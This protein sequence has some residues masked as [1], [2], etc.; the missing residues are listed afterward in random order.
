MH[1][2]FFNDSS[3]DGHSGCSHGLAI[4][5]SAAV[6]LGV[7]IFLSDIDSASFRYI[8]R[9]G[10]AGPLGRANFNI[11]RDLHALFRSGRT[12]LHNQQCEAFPFLHF[13]ANTC[14][15]LYLLYL[16]RTVQSKAF[17]N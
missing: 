9:H 16:Q 8:L 5:N 14:Y 1:L 12:N 7:Q 11:L 6:N 13:L 3:T 4:I 17:F 15:P 10:I 2:I